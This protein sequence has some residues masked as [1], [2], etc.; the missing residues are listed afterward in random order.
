MR[1]GQGGPRPRRLSV[2]ERVLSGGEREIVAGHV[3]DPRRRVLVGPRRAGR[4][5]AGILHGQRRRAGVDQLQ[6]RRFG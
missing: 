3:L 4:V 1:P 2:L 6:A 5:R